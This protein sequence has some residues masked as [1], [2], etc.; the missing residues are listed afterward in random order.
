MAKYTEEKLESLP[1][2]GRYSWW[3]RKGW[4]RSV[5]KARDF[6]ECKGILEKGNALLSLRL[7]REVRF[8][9]KSSHVFP[10]FPQRTKHRVW[11]VGQTMHAER[12]R[13]FP[14]GKRLAFR[15]TQK[16]GRQL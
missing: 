12:K 6:W 9:R 4:E 13:R 3:K 7:V 5:T 14:E 15:K 2:L 8:A 1:K 16:E 11:A 10:P